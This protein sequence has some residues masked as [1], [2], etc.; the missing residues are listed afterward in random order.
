VVKKV[1]VVL[2]SSTEAFPTAGLALWLELPT[3][4]TS[5]P[6]PKVGEDCWNSSLDA[7]LEV[8]AASIYLE[9]VATNI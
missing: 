4:A 5:I 7:H 1:T 9:A 2:V 6:G 8:V 3:V